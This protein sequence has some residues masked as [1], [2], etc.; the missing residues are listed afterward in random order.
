MIRALKTSVGF[1]CLVLV[2]AGLA[3]VA[4][5]ALY[6]QSADNFTGSYYIDGGGSFSY[7]FRTPVDFSS[8]PDT[9]NLA[10]L[11]ITGTPDSRMGTSAVQVNNVDYSSLDTYYVSSSGD[12]STYKIDLASLLAVWTGGADNLPLSV[13]ISH[14]GRDDGFSLDSALLELNYTNSYPPPEDNPVPE[15]ATLLLFGSGLVCVGAWGRK[16]NRNAVVER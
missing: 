2:V 3:G 15:P 11:L 4:N 10:Y 5:A 12:V 1:I 9:L 8:P 13:S 14:H 16:R 6:T 7:T